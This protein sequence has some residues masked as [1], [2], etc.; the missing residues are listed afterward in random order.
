MLLMIYRK[1]EKYVDKQCENIAT[2][3]L[4]MSNIY[5]NKKDTSD[6]YGTVSFDPFKM[7]QQKKKPKC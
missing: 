1:L 4:D 6:F 2:C 3:A 7:S 5:S